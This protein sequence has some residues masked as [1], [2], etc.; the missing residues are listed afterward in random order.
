MCVA[1]GA[2]MAVC[3][4]SEGGEEALALAAGVMTAIDPA[5]VLCGCWGDVFNLH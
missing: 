4:Q 3:A 2:C 5:P 1:A